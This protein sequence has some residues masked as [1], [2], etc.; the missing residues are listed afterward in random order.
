M[1]HDMIPIA[2]RIREIR[3]LNNLTQRQFAA[4]LKL[5]ENAVAQYETGAY[6]PTLG[7]VVKIAHVFNV[8]TDYLLG[9]ADQHGKRDVRVI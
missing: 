3:T 7:V 2:E 1:Q 8:T 6:N 4:T 5:P 9:V